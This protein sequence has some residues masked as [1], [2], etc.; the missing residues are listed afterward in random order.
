MADRYPQSRFERFCMGLHTIKLM[1]ASS[2]FYTKEGLLCIK[3]ADPKLYGTGMLQHLEKL[4][5][6]LVNDNFTFTLN[7]QRT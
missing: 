3:C 7:E 5:F 6:K 2:E 1:Q 4:G